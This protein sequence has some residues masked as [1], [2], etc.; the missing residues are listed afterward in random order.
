MCACSIPRSVWPVLV[1]A[2]EHDGGAEDRPGER[3]SHRS[4][5]EPREHEE[6]HGQEVDESERE[7]EPYRAMLVSQP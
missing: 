5:E 2:P 6:R 3:V 7:P 1:D 4:L